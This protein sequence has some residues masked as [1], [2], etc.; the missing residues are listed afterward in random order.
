MPVRTFL[1]TNVLVYAFD[2]DSGDKRLRARDMLADRGA[3]DFVISAQVLGEF[4]VTVTR[5]LARPLTAQ[6]AARAVDELGSLPVVRIDTV[7]VRAAIDTSQRAQLSYWDA[8]I[9]EAAAS[10]GCARILTEDLAD[11]TSIRGVRIEDPFGDG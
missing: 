8:L 7:L 1:D 10:A 3:N 11:G 2:H 4:F 9:V 6:A 5:K